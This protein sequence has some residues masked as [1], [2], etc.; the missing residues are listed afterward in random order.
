MNL[1]IGICDDN[2][3]LVAYLKDFV[4]NWNNSSNIKTFNNA[5]EFLFNYEEDK[6]FDIL[7]LDI[8]MG[9]INGVELSKEIRK[10]NNKAQIIFITGYSDYIAEGYEVS[11]LH[12]LMKPVN[13]DKLLETLNRAIEK[14]DYTENFLFI[15]TNDISIKVFLDEIKYIEVI[16]NY[17]N[18]YCNEFYNIKQTLIETIEKLDNRFFKI[19][20]SFVVNL[21]YINKIT[22][23]E[24]FLNDNSTIPLPRGAYDK[25]NRAIIERM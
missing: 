22:K 2:E 3:D 8:E 10:Y 15:K 14:L 9:N 25:L 17:I 13:E 12:Y 18:I 4:L 7:L 16:K 19:G 1:N 11:A 20:R 24:V 21:T 5:E 6:N 23:N